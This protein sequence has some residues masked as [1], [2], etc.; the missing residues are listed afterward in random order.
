VEKVEY[1]GWPNCYRLSNGVVD[2]VVTTDVGPRIIRYGFTGERNE[3]KEFDDMVGKTGGDEW[4][5]YGGH[6]FWIAPEQK[7]RSYYPDNFLVKIET[8]GKTVR[9]T[10]E[11]ESTTGIQK[12]IDI[13]LAETGSH[14]TVTH[15]LMN[16]NLWAVELAPWALTVMA[17]GGKMIMPLPPRGPHEGQLLP[18]SL[19][20]MWAYTDMADPRWTWGT[21]YILLQQDPKAEKPQKIGMKNTDGWLAYANGGHLFVKKFDYVTGGAYPDFGCS[22]ETFTNGEMLEAETVAPMVKLQPGQT[23]EH[24]EHWFLFKDAPTPMCDADVEKNVLPKVQSAK[25]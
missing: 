25:V 24:V 10:P 6:R 18:T 1:N 15:R 5:I 17:Q 16:K 2:L 19:L 22:V 9:L 11:L 4:R 12:E 21:K 20:S 3:F 8:H 14:V 23:A 7:P 13:E